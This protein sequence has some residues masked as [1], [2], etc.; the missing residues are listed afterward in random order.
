MP[1][2]A[3]A[4]DTH[5]CPGGGGPILPSG[6][7]TVLIDFLPA[8]MV[9]A[10]VTCTAIGD[11]PIIRGSTGVFIYNLP[12]ARMGDQTLLGGAILTG[13]PTCEIGEIGLPPSGSVGFGGLVAGLVMSGGVGI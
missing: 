8:A 3:R 12:A 1:P 10:Q 11:D 7:L 9:T 6:E 13:S 5:I 2:A 4:T